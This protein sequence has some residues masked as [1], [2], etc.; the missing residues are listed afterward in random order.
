MTA[1]N[2]SEGF[3]NYHLDREQVE[4]ILSAT[5]EGDRESLVGCMAE[6]HVADIADLLEQIEDDQ[7]NA[8]VTLWG[9]KFNIG[10]LAELEE[11]ILSEVVALLS[12][13]QIA[14]SV[15]ELESDDIV[16]IVAD[17]VPEQQGLF[18][19]ALGA[20]DRA[21]VQRSLAFPEGTAG[22][23]MKPE[24]VFVPDSWRVGDAI[25][26]LRARKD[27]PE[28]FHHVMLVTPKIVP[29][30]QV[31]LGRLMAAGRDVLLLDIADEG[32]QTIPA[33]RQQH[34]V[35]YAFSQYH[36]ISAPVVNEHG[37]LVGVIT[38]DDAMAALEDEAE[39]DIKRLAGVGGES[40]SD[41]VLGTAAL[42]FPWLFLNLATAVLA[43]IVIA[44][45][46]D[47]IQ[48]MVALAILMPIVASMGGN[49]GTQ[50][51]TVV[52]RAL[53]TRDLTHSN[54]SRVIKRETLIGVCNGF[55]FAGIVGAVA[56]VWFDSQTLGFV[57]AL[58]MII[59]MIVANVSGILIPLGLERMRVDPAIAS[60]VFVTT[61]TDVV[62]FY[63]FLG[64][65]AALI[66]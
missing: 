16:D 57:I 6:L 5:A 59:N 21:A 11:R 33:L 9:D 7:R 61:V 23:L 37:R 44:R 50:T 18:L 10:V 20:S 29:V 47:T 1:E 64:I 28:D 53:A 12:R 43:S 49:A 52:V 22:R 34:E 32:F 15:V 48:T 17:L 41:R 31:S 4:A 55:L 58:A 42:R 39:E 38:I 46:A 66:L 27:L 60:S 63:A 65:A 51:L 35:A 56:F 40:L 36:L 26:F 19:N 45:F 30:G 14:E 24:T 2:S 54:S 62:G 13:R 3:S 8:L 25:D